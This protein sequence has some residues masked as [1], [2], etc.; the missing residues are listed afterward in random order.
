MGK[1]TLLDYQCA[2]KI[3]LYQNAHWKDPELHLHLLKFSNGLRH[4]SFHHMNGEETFRVPTS[5]QEEVVG[6]DLQDGFFLQGCICSSGFQ[7]TS[8]YIAKWFS[9][10]RGR[11]LLEYSFSPMTPQHQEYLML[12]YIQ[13]T[14]EETTAINLTHGSLDDKETVFTQCNAQFNLHLL[15]GVQQ[16]SI[17]FDKEGKKKELKYDIPFA[18][19]NQENPLSE[20]DYIIPNDEDQQKIFRKLCKVP[21]DTCLDYRK[22]LDDICRAALKEEIIPASDLLKFASQKK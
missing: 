3:E 17:S 7:R 10:E 1:I 22:T 6:L 20:F 19:M 14:Q 9:H 8:S 11:A 15:Y 16:I 18:R 21:S 13:E 5:F 4:V 12:R 2:E